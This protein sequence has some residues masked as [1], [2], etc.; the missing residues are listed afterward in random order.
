MGRFTLGL[1]VACGLASGALGGPAWADTITIEVQPIDVPDEKLPRSNVADAPA[2]FEPDSWQGP[3]AGKSNWHARYLADGDAL[4]DLFPDDAA[5]LTLADIASINYFTKR[6][7]GTPAGRD[8]WIQIYTRPTGVGDCASWYKNRFINDYDAH[9]DIDSWTQHSTDAGAMTFNKNACGAGA[10]QTL[11]DL[12]TNHGGELVE[13]I[14]IQTDSAWNGFDGFVDGL[15]ITLLNGNVGRVNF[16]TDATTVQIAPWQVPDEQ[17]PRVNAADAPHGFGPDSWQGPTTAKSNWHARY[18]A[19]GDHL[20]A[21]FPAKAA[22]LT[23]ADIASI[24]YFT[25]RPTGTPAGRDWWI[26]VYTRPTGVGDC[27]SWYKNRFINNYDG[28]TTIETWTQHSTAGNGMTFNK[29]GCGVGPEQTLDDLIT[30]HGGELV[31]MISVQTDSGW[32]GFD[33]YIDGLEITL[34]T[35]EVGR[36]NFGEACDTGG[37]TFHVDDDTGSDTNN[38]CQDSLLPCATIQYAIDLACVVGNTVAVA[39][40]TYPESPNVT[41][42]LTVLGT[43]GRDATFIELQTGPTYLGALTVSGE[44]VTVD[45]F[46]I[47]GRDAACP[48]LASTNVFVMPGLGDVA[49]ENSRLLVGEPGPCTNG[50]DGFG[51]IN[52][53]APANVTNSLTVADSI[54]EPLTTAGQRIFYV[55][56]GVDAFNFLR[57]SV[58]GK[59]NGTALVQ[60]QN[61]LVEDNEIDGQGL[62]GGGLGTWGYPDA[63]VWGHTTFRGNIFT[64]L[65][66]AAIAVFESNDV[67]VECNRFSDS[68]VGVRVSDG[69]G[70]PNFDPTTIDIHDNSF[71][72]NAT[73][74]VSNLAST[75]GTISAGD[76]WWGCVTGPGNPGCDAVVGD[77]DVTPVATSAPACV[78]CSQDSDCDD[79]LTCTGAETCDTDTAMCQTGTPVDCADQCLTGVCLEPSGTCEPV[80]DGT[81]CDTGLV[82]M[83]SIDDECQSGVC[84]V[85]P[86]GGDDDSDG[87]CD[88][89]DNCPDDF[90]PNQ[91]DVDFDNIG[92]ACDPSTS[93]VSL[94]VSVARLRYDYSATADRGNARLRALVNDNDTNG[95]LE[96]VLLSNSVTVRVRDAGSFDVTLPITGCQAIGSRGYVRCISSNVRARFRPTRQGPLIYNVVLVARNLS[97][98]QTGTVAPVGP[99]VVD[100]VQGAVTRTDDISD[101]NPGGTR[102]LSCIDR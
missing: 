1:L 97:E 87:V 65:G 92:D 28:H 10:E 9:A 40:G 78:S 34:T 60:A 41:K 82:D 91:A 18:L 52:T 30:N 6:P 36:V 69:F 102:R 75:P 32:G 27:A 98:L 63:N 95:D 33:G 68:N 77:V 15:E 54:I 72:D 101:C 86:G 17:L 55:N 71:L 20:S 85:L 21:L 79:G 99:V 81:V 2:G 13:M 8:W 11:D 26:Q 73:S 12:I 89:D 3:F 66:T 22:T 48:T 42:S 80:A 61:G 45:G 64:G 25:K 53:Y 84:E 38:D 46:T 88:A 94:V 37:L 19:D 74:G 35:G 70:T 57:N 56:P 7:T 29:N 44:N 49:V 31:E 24:S 14:S 90:N 5:T 96:G 67:V 39:P 83:C 62:G 50:D 100:L 16:E 47:V 76:N 51:F 59:F 4:S 43:G 58:T 93:P 23:I